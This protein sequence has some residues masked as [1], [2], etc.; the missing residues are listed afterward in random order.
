MSSPCPELRAMILA[1]VLAAAPLAHAADARVLRVCADPDNLPYSNEHGDGF[2][3]RIAELLATELH[4]TLQYDWWPQRRGY[5]RRTL[6][7]NMCDVLIGVPAEFDRVSTTRPYYR[8]GYVFLTRAGEAAPAFDSAAIRSRRIGVQLIGNDMAATP[9]GHALTRAGATSNVTGF[10]VFGEGP[11]AQ[12]MVD[13]LDRGSIDAALLWG[14]QAGLF[15]ARAAHP[16][17]MRIA[18]APAGTPEPFAFDVAVGVKRGNKALLAELDE[19]LARRQGDI[20]RILTEY[21]VPLL[22][23]ADAGERK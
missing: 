8:S 20:E 19:V 7:A 4:A 12:R 6:G 2:E 5:V 1:T 11:A 21:K 23:L 17:Q 15:A 14:P 13:A 22:P 18:A 3:N 9:A 10:T 16:L